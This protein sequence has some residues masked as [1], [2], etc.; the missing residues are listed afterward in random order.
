MRQLLIFILTI[1]FCVSYAQDFVYPSIKTT[2]QN[3]HD[4][5]PAGWAILD[6]ACGDLNKDGI[7]DAAI[8]LQL[9]DSISLVNSTED[10]VVTKPRILLLLFKNVAG[11]QFVLKE[12]SNSFILQND[13][14][15]M[16]D[17]YQGILIEKGILKIDFHLFSNMGSWYTTSSNYKFLYNGFNFIL[18]G[19]DH[20]TIHRATLDY[21]DYSYNFQSKKRSYTKGNEQRGTKKTS[22]KILTKKSFYTFKTCKQPFSLEIEPGVYL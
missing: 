16:D 1:F 15:T 7:K 14:P 6:S 20:L 18:I 9:K 12:K 2:G 5:I 19:A 11:N 8:I 13:N 3:I 17:P 22:I 4:F 10:T 21:E